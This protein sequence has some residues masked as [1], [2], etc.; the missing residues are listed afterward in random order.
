MRKSLKEEIEK[1]NLFKLIDIN[2]HDFIEL[3]H[4][5]LSDEEISRELNINK[6]FAK[7]LRKEA[8]RDW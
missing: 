1:R 6:T 8:E 2:F 5:G 7:E 4:E 3:L